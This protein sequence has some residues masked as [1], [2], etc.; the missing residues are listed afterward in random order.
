MM[1][2]IRIVIALIA[3]LLF[4]P[5]MA[6]ATAHGQGFFTN[7]F[8]GGGSSSTSANSC[9][10]TKTQLIACDEGTT[11]GVSAI[12]NLIK[13]TVMILTVLIGVV[14]VGGIAYAAILYSSARDNQSQ[15]EQSRTIMRNIVIGLLLYG[16]T[17]AILN[18]LIPGGI[19]ATP[20]EPE[21]SVAPNP[22]ASVVPTE[23]P[24]P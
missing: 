5:Q 10:D 24:T 11:T 17:I 19:I 7:L 18:W 14:A 12:S 15:V 16:F 2:K 3:A 9:G 21:S 22:T 20:G 23:S 4:V 13:M 6:P 1:K 8:G